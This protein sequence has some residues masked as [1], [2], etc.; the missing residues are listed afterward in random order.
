MPFNAFWIFLRLGNSACD[1]WGLILV[2]GFF[3]VL[4][5]LPPSDF[6]CH[7]SCCNK[8][9][10]TSQQR[11]ITLCVLE[12]LSQQQNSLAATSPR[13]LVWFDFVRLVAAIRQILFQGCAKDVHKNSPVISP[14]TLDFLV[15]SL[16]RHSLNSACVVA[17]GAPSSIF[18]QNMMKFARCM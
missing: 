14:V 17:R 11:R 15:S 2:Q 1:F 4:I 5:F 13:N 3:R 10:D 7:L 6:R 8:L 16:S 18:H 9:N 12:N